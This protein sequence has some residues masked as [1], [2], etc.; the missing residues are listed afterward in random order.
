[1]TP[2]DRD[3]VA[4]FLKKWQ[5]SEGNERANY[6][7]FFG[8]WCRA[9]G[10]EEP[11]PKGTVPGDPYCFD[12]DIKFYSDRAESTRFADFY[13]AGCFLIEAKQ[14]S[15]SSAKGHGK[16]GTKIYRDNLQKAFNQAKS[17]A[18][19]RML[20]S[21][22]PF[23]MVC[24]IGSHFEIWQGF[25]GEYGGYGARETVNLADL[26]QPEV[27]DR[28]VKIF[29][30][31]QALNPEKLR[32]RVTREVA[33]E[34]AKLSRW[35]EEQG[36]DPQ[37]TASFL[38]RCIFT[39]FA[40][41]VALLKGE[42]FTKALR[43]RWIPNPATFQPE[44]ESLWETMNR[45][46]SFGFEKVLKFNGSFFEN[47]TAIALPKEQL[48]I[49]YGAA[50]KDW[51]QVEPAI[52]GT[53]L[54]RAL[55]KAER[56]RLGAHYTPRSYVERLVR[57]VVMEPLRSQW[58]AIELEVKRLLDGSAT[59]VAKAV[60]EIQGF[61]EQL[62]SIRILDPAC[63]TGNFLYVSLDLLKGLEQEVLTRLVDVAGEVQ[64]NVLEQVNPSQF[65]GIEINPRA[66]E[67]A[68]LVIWIGY[69]QWHFKRFGNAEPSMPV[70]RAFDNIECRDAVLTYDG[71]E[72]DIDLKTGQVRTR[73]GGQMMTHPVTGQ[74]VPD[75]TNQVIIY[76]YRNARPSEWP[77]SD[78]IVSNP[79]FIGNARMREKL[80][81][82][83]T[84]TLR[85]VYADV[86]D[87]VDFVMYWWHKA[88]D[89][90]IK[91]QTGTFGLI[92]TNSINQP[93]LRC[94]LEKQ[95]Q[96]APDLQ[97]KFVIPDHPWVDDGAD[98]RIAMTA[99]QLNPTTQSLG[100]VVSETESPDRDFSEV[101]IEYKDTQA[102]F[103]NLRDDSD[104][105]QIASLKSNEGLAS[106]GIMLGGKGFLLRD[107][108]RSLI[109]PDLIKRYVNG[110]DLLRKSRNLVVIDAFGLSQGELQSKYPR[111]YEWLLNN[112]KPAREA[113]N[114]PKL[115]KEWWLYRRSNITIRQALSNLRR[116]VV[117]V[118]TAKHRIF[119][120]VDRD[121]IC[122][123]KILIVALEDSYALGILS[124]AIH[125]RWAL[126][127]GGRLEDRPVYVKTTCFDPFP[128]PDPD[129]RLK[130]EIRELGDRL[131]THRKTVQANHPDITITGM[132][133][134]LEKLRAG[135]PFT[136]KDRELNDRALVSTLKQ[137][138]DDLD[139]AVFRAYG[140]DDLI[141]QWER[142]QGC[143]SLPEE[144]ANSLDEQIL[145]RLVKL[146]AERA[147]EERNGH[148]RWLRPDYQAPATQT[149]QTA[150][151]NLIDSPAP[152]APAAE[153]QPWPTQPKA[154]L[155]AI[156]DLLRSNPGNW[157]IE[158][159]AAQ[160]KGKITDKR[161]QVIRENL[162][163]LEWFGLAI[164]QENTWHYAAP[165]PIA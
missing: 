4:A 16:R 153:P 101:V 108:Q 86:P 37:V 36:H 45:G 133:N 130:Q 20:G 111:T 94:V 85:Q 59:A 70:L 39:M 80:G 50:A 146:N 93:R 52:F 124:S 122:D 78:Y 129:D 35:L 42:V 58:E 68:E 97:L 109:E 162:D 69:L 120:F 10:V 49:L 12:K 125:V 81:D 60:A 31:P 138:H 136:D 84:E 18:Y 74:E 139:R 152:I 38:M 115:K 63:G 116:Y 114:D 15:D 91:N 155:A 23:L 75:L 17:Y 89:L 51:S 118:E 19:N 34:L 106:R 13:K 61:L 150:I 44:I 57:P 5:G 22:P 107:S 25:S 8:D 163:R 131:D 11:P 79:P 66:K 21:L 67:I 73:W 143:A 71:V 90:A 24:D 119:S 148:I 158:Q 72:P 40:E 33:A 46:G 134:L 99:C 144:P 141:P 77:E 43:D 88:A 117:T 6:Q 47:A 140:W 98:V 2:D 54:E 123:N 95:F 137:I 156:R 48:E 65:L 26:A 127:V 149:T 102:I 135:Q 82:G 3:R 27:F 161:R 147:A 121:I 100:S 104:L 29:T 53:L 64:L 76:R 83:Y 14:G 92:T 157:S 160:F 87:T 126:A 28:F 96:K 128:F 55:D 159:I 7:S 142:A 41:D 132:Y 56:S 145:E 151:A 103:S 112:V 1:M 164:Q 105:E 62:R 154:Q 30:D 9:L 113:N 32:A 110:R 165:S